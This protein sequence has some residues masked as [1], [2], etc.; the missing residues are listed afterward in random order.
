[1]GLFVLFAVVLI[2]LHAPLLRL[3][4][5]WDE[6]GY[7]IPAARDLFSGS[8]IPY[9]TPSNAH[10]PLVMAWLALAWKIFGQSQIVTRCAMLL[11]AAFSLLGFFRLARTVS[12][13]TVAACSTLLVGIYPVFFAQSSLAQVDLPA[14]GLMFWGLESHFRNKL[15]ARASS[16]SLVWFSLAALA[17]ETAI[18]IPV[19]LI[20]WE[21][22]GRFISTSGSSVAKATKQKAPLIGTTESRALPV[23][24][25]RTT[26]RIGFA[27][28][29]LLLTPVI[30]L[31]LWYAYHYARTG[32]VF[33]NPEFFRYNVQSTLHAMRILLALLL[34]IW[35]TLGYLDLYVLTLACV[36]AMMFAPIKEAHGERTRIAIPVQFA[37]LAIAMVYLVSLSIVGGAVLAR[38]MLPVVPMVILVFV[39]TIWRRLR[40]WKAVIAVI[41]LA[42]VSALFINPPYGFSPEDNLAYRDY[43]RLHERAER[44]LEQRYPNVRV[45]TAWPASDELTR[46]YLGFISKPMQVVKI[47]DFSAEQVLSAAPARFDVVLVF[48]TKYQPEHTIFDRWRRWQEWKSRYFGYHVDLTPEV[49][50]S[51]LGG[52]VVYINRRR[53]QWVGVIE[54]EKIEQAKLLVAH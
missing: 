18:L 26:P 52:N 40:A 51:V 9:S 33:G 22:G 8:L 1:V 4:Y 6:A 7:Y 3:P 54:M 13:S 43:I 49:A 48:S 25:D 35:Q 34:R 19:A 32:F 31:A 41:A 28:I 14:A 10:P 36:V 15:M 47:E 45:L 53:G 27:N 30:P 29:W 2:A 17:K 50:A 5:F 38:Y 24:S 42:F 23:A 37:F 12:N 20:L 46:P 21:L 44:F 16:P 11:L 39:S